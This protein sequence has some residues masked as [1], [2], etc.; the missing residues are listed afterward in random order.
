MGHQAIIMMLLVQEDIAADLKD[1]K[2]WTLL[3]LATKEG[4]GVIVKMLL[5]WKDVAANSKDI[6]GRMSQR[7]MKKL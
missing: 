1:N 4:Y 7:G 6:D 5:G 2:G 3:S